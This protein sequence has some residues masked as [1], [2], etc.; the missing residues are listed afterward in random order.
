MDVIDSRK[1]S[2]RDVMRCDAMR[3][4]TFSQKPRLL[5]LSKEYALTH[6]M[7]KEPTG[8]CAI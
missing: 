5:C 4:I 2:F 7:Q 3:D 6:D 8:G 1:R